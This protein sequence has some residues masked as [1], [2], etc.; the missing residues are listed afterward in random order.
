MRYTQYFCF[1]CNNCGHFIFNWPIFILYNF[2]RLL[3]LPFHLILLMKWLY[4]LTLY[5]RLLVHLMKHCLSYSQG[6]L[7]H[8]SNLLN[9]CLLQIKTIEICWQLFES[10]HLFPPVFTNLVFLLKEV[11]CLIYWIECMYLRWYCRWV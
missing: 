6:T 8:F 10:F 7:L 3:F 9:D 5:L 2:A 4:H 1:V 11:L